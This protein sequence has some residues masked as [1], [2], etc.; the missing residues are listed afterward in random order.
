MRISLL[1]FLIDFLNIFFLFFLS[2]FDTFDNFQVF[3]RCHKNIRELCL[4]RSK[5]HLV[6]CPGQYHVVAIGIPELL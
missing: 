4:W 6:G 3:I 2:L 1:A 5:R